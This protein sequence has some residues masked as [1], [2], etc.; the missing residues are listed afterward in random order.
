MKLS[1]ASK[2]A[3]ERNYYQSCEWFCDFK[4]SADRLR[5]T[6]E[7]LGS[8]LVLGANQLIRITGTGL[9]KDDS[10]LTLNMKCEDSIK[11]AVEASD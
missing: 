11:A 7:Y 3:I 9:S 8:R 10:A 6:F 4:E 2:R 1:S 5:D